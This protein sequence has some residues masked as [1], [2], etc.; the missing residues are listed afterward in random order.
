MTSL[1]TAESRV[2]D[3]H[4]KLRTEYLQNMEGLKKLLI[5]E[6]VKYFQKYNEFMIPSP[7]EGEGLNQVANFVHNRNELKHKVDLIGPHNIKVKELY[8]MYMEALEHAKLELE[9]KEKE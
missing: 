2:E 3:L 4:N 5:L 9:K 7:P 6:L 1:N 8:S